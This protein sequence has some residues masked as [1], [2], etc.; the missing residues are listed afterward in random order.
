MARIHRRDI[1]AWH[2]PGHEN[3]H[4]GL[5]Q[6]TLWRRCMF[7]VLCILAAACTPTLVPSPPSEA[8]ATPTAVPSA[9]PLPT[10]TPT[11]VPTATPIPPAQLRIIWPDAVSALAPVPIEVELTA[12]PGEA[13]QMHLWVKIVDPAGQAFAVYNLENREGYRY[14]ANDMLQLP[15]FPLGG[16]WSVHVEVEG[17]LAVEGSRVLFFT[18]EPIPLRQLDTSLPRPVRLF[19]PQAFSERS[20]QGDAA[21]GNWSWQHGDGIISLWWAPGPTE[22]LQLS[23]AVTMLE[24][25]FP[26][27][28]RPRILDA[29]ETTWDGWVTFVFHVD[30]F[31]GQTGMAWVVQGDDDWLYVLEIHS[32]ENGEIPAIIEAVASSFR[33]P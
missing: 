11:A 22:K 13:G 12:P 19:I 3:R 17:S 26:E 31:D 32:L 14:R 16:R 5:S 27:D 15:L 6:H 25:T 10:W 28:P 30:W 33:I 7:G 2:K 1:A 24:A 29:A 18:P 23:N 8:T 21:A 9:T 4:T 20:R